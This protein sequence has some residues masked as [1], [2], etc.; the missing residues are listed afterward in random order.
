[1]NKKSYISVLVIFISLVLASTSAFP[2][3]KTIS[4]PY[5]S[6]S[7]P[8]WSGPAAAKMIL[9]SPIITAHPLYAYK[10]QT[11]LWNYINTH[12]NALWNPL[13]PG[14]H[15]DPYAMRDCL[16]EYDTRPGFTYVI[17]DTPTYSP[18]I[19]QKIVY[20]INNYNVPPAVPIDGG[21]NWVAVLGVDTTSDPALGPYT[22]NWF[23]IN[24]PRDPILGNNRYV[25]YFDWENN[26]TNSVFKH[27]TTPAPFPNNLLKMAV[28][29]PEDPGPLIV[30]PPKM[31]L[32]RE[33]VLSPSE[34][35]EAALKALNE[36]NLMDK[37]DFQNAQ[38]RISSG[39]PIL[40][41]RTAG[42]M[43]TD[44]YI[45]P[46]V[47]SY[48]IFWKRLTAAVLID[49][50]SGAFLEASG[51]KKAISYPYLTMS[52]DRARGLL[53][54]K[55]RKLEGISGK[56]LTIEMPTLTW[57]PGLSV[58]PYFPLWETRAT[59]KGVTTLRYLDFEKN[60]R[61]PSYYPAEQ[62]QE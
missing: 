48:F 51:A 1:M 21:L 24:D 34:A 56:D 4:I 12:A 39:K 11:E 9:E 29:D 38:K 61:R 41:K 20:T 35:R 15:T 19:S 10:T 3:Q 45:V 28:C 36:Y 47:K 27:I 54:R 57:K 33:T 2:W 18:I 16:K 13:Y 46:L 6:Q 50:Y 53:M 31:P 52:L 43:R 25:S 59:I 60:I 37:K 7:N 5:Y 40:V 22:I 58:N 26:G 55:I 44:Y 17:Y 49:A 62:R 23:L 14:V 42:R 30:E 32:R 8:D